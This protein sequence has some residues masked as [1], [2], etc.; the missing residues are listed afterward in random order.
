MPL[1]GDIKGIT[2]CFPKGDSSIKKNILAY[3][4]PLQHFEQV[5]MPLCFRIY[6]IY[7]RVPWNKIIALKNWYKTSERLN[8]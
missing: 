3:F 8:S 1:R 4:Q 6:V 5:N 2:C 7:S